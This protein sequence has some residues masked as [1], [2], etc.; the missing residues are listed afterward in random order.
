MRIAELTVDNFR[1]HTHTTLQLDPGV[2][3]LV[4]PNGQGKTNLLEAI[5]LSC[6]GRGWRTSRDNEMVQFGKDNA[7]VQVTAV[8]K[9]GAVD[10]A[11]QLGTGLKKS[12]AINRVPIAKVAELMGQI[13][14][15][16][17]SPD[18][19]KLVK[20]APADRRRFINIDLSQIDKTYFYALARYNKILQQRNAYLKDNSDPREL[21]IWDGQLVKQGKIIIAKRQEFIQKLTPYVEAKHKELTGGQE[22]ISLTY[23]TCADLEKE[24]LAARER[25][26]RLRTTTVGPHRDDLAIT[27]NGQD[28]RVFG[29]Q[30][31][32]RT[33]AL[34]IKLAELDLF[35]KLTGERPILLLDDVFS[36]LDSSRRT[37]L[38]I[39][40]ANTQAIITATDVPTS[41]KIFTVING[42]VKE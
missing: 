34:S 20:E 15:I 1:N 28:V 35:T 23:E 24:L 26:L 40:I 3:V 8:K 27:I 17:F 31:Q 19:L 32:Q 42:T 25:D 2:N 29:S 22:K 12:I 41:G 18:E 10:I 5:Y 11:I 37:R 6:V 7:L 4:G 13:N 33:V 14:C 9:F 16:F 30:G 21:A 39:A 36:E 38:L